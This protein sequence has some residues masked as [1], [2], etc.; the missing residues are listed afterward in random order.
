MRRRPLP[1]AFA[2]V[3]LVV[4]Q[5]VAFAHEAK[6]RHIEC[7]EHG[8]QIEAANLVGTHLCGHDHWVGV[9]GNQGRDHFDCAISHLLHQSAAP[10]STPSTAAPIVVTTAHDTPLA[11]SFAIADELYLIAPKTSPP[12]SPIASRS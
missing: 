4:G 6:T 11:T 1:A 8:E 2:V 3:L 12:T 5:L 10:S 7:A 9:E